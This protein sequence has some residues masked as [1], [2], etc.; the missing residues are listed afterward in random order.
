[1]SCIYLSEIE[2]EILELE[3]KLE[4]LKVERLRLSNSTHEP[5]SDSDSKTDY[6]GPYP[7]LNQPML[8]SDALCTFLAVSAGTRMSRKE[9]RNGVV[10]YIKKHNLVHNGIV[11]ADIPLNNLI[12]IDKVNLCS[13]MCYF[14]K[15]H[16][17][18]PVS[19]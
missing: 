1:M 7:W 12:G 13:I 17:I 18:K 19:D 6:G 3:T 2:A 5:E 4:N 8:I 14:E 9:V 10:G 11:N 15:K 16:I